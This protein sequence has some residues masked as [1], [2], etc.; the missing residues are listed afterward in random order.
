MTKFIN[1]YFSEI[2]QINNNLNK[3]KIKDIL[4]VLLKVKKNNGRIFFIGV[5]GSAGNASHAVNDFRKLCNIDSLAPTDNVSELSAR[6][7]DDGWENVFADYLKVSKL[8]K[9][10]CIFI[11]SVGGGSKINN[12][13]VNLIKAVDYALKIGCKICGIVGKKDGYVVK[14]SQTILTLPEVD[15][16]LI[17]PLAESYQSI[18]LHCLVSHPKIKSNSTKW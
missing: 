7:N 18:V 11:L 16:D 15:K 3:K 10:D 5:G 12:I 6:T 8:S 17:T 13:S 14:K 1:H 2:D 4:N 9:K